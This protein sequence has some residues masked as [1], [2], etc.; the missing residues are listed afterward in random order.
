MNLSLGPTL[1][2]AVYCDVQ[3]YV[4]GSSAYTLL[5]FE[6]LGASGAG[7]ITLSSSIVASLTAAQAITFYISQPAN[8]NGVI[9]AG[10]NVT[11]IFLI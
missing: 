6:P 3:I 8:L 4:N 2:G 11:G 5:Q 1:T 9:N 7:T 10:S